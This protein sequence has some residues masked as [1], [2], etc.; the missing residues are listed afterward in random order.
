MTLAAQSESTETASAH[1][2]VT[3]VAR[4]GSEV[5]DVSRDDV[6]VYEGNNRDSVTDWVPAQGNNAALE[7]Y[8]LLDDGS[9]VT[10]GTQLP[11]LR[12]F[13]AAQPASTKVGIAYMENGS[14]KVLQE[15]TSDHT[16][17]ANALRL[18][19][20]IPGI[21]GSPYFSVSDLVKH[22]P[23][24]SARREV[25]MVTDG[26]DHYYNNRDLD[27]PYLS[28][29][30]D[31][32]QRAGILV[33]GIYSPGSSRASHSYWQTY[34]G[35]IY[36]AKLAADT[37][38][39]SYYIGF[40]GP[41]VSFSPYLDDVGNRLGHQYLLTF[42]AQPEKKSGFQR[43]KVTT[44]VSNANLVSANKVYVTASPR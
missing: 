31:D 8:I 27:D 42:V 20:G 3:V 14:A 35:Q 13:I 39:Q 25:V 2:L 37:G 33:F 5:P 44:E 38:G 41:P 21:N 1:M 40:N 34:W 18:P 32:A 28:A 17:A 26:I 16:L 7:L 22:W 36:L 19:M 9:N 24:S 6:M 12:Q 29:A 10:L 4:H 30:I 43:V 15:V 23:Q 11:Q